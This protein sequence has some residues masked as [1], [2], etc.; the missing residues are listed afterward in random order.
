MLEK[1][2]RITANVPKELLDDACSISGAGI[3]ETLILGLRLI[4]RSRAFD[5]ALKLKRKISFN[6]DLETSRERNRR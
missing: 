5:K 1:N 3:T 6:I 4:K 2:R